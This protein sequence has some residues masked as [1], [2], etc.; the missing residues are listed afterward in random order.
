MGRRKKRGEGGRKRKI[1]RSEGDGGKE[2]KKGEE[3]GWRNGGGDQRKK[4]GG[5]GGRGRKNPSALT[6]T[7]QRMLI[8][9]LRV[10]RMLVTSKIENSL[11]YNKFN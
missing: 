11:F 3:E 7:K 2:K 5:R 9:K 1:G 6:L 4:E 8:F 10:R